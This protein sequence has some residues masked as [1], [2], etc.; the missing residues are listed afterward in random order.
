MRCRCE[1]DIECTYVTAA[2]EAEVLAHGRLGDL[3]VDIVNPSHLDQMLFFV[4]LAETIGGGDGAPGRA[5]RRCEGRVE[6]RVVWRWS[7]S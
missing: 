2:V 3:E 4:G 5:G 7:S 1:V 6:V